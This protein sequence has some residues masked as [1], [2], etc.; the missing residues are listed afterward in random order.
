MYSEI[1]LNPAK[2]LT[3]PVKPPTYDDVI[4]KKPKL[5]ALESTAAINPFTV[6]EGGARECRKGGEGLDMAW[7]TFFS[8]STYMQCAVPS[9]EEDTMHYN[10][11]I[12]VLPKIPR[13]A[14]QLSNFCLKLKKV[15]K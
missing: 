5:N 15:L 11:Y 3:A 6:H 4:K 1:P 12:Y 10:T 14:G 8:R 7:T 9:P 2:M 13:F